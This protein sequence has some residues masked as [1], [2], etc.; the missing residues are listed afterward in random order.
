MSKPK[1]VIL[2]AG[3]GGLVTAIRLQKLIKADEVEVTLVNKHDYH[4]MTTHLHMPAA[5]TDHHENARVAIKDLID[6]R[7]IHFIKA[8]VQQIVPEEKKVI[9]PDEVL[10]YDYLVVGLGSETETFGIPGLREYAMTINSINS[11]RFIRQHTQYMFAKYKLDSK[12]KDY[13]TI[14]VG[15]AGFT[16]TEFVGELADRIPDLCQMFDVDPSLV[17]I[18]NIEASPTALPP[19]LPNDLVEYGMDVMRRKGVQY[20]LSTAIKACEPGGVLLGDGQFIPAGTVIWSG[21]VRGNSLLQDA[22][23]HVQRGRVKVD[24]YLRSLQFPDVFITG[25]CSIVMSP[26]GTP[27]P[28]NAQIAVQQGCNTAK[29]LFYSLRGKPLRPFA[30]DYKGTVA[31]LGRGEAIGILKVKKVKG[32]LAAFLKKIIDARYLFL[33]GGI[34]LIFKKMI[35]K[36]KQ[37]TRKRHVRN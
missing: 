36:Q 6:E 15:G 37:T 27:Y 8:T 31:S 26:E 18:I 9:L 1:V 34:P 2:G 4:Y 11:V 14:V 19:G 20:K 24:D 23:F 25:D 3:Y 30:Y 10:T 35:F 12:H 17:Q 7:K 33:I 5:G 29:N 13:L 21:G 22:G 16:G 28:A 32:R